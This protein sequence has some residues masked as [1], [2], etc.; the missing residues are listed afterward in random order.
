MRKMVPIGQLQA[1]CEVARVEGLPQHCG[2]INQTENQYH[3]ASIMRD[4][5]AHQIHREFGAIMG[6]GQW[7]GL[8]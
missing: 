1:F 6:E 7:K 5:Q 2:E 3:M 8:V 4:A